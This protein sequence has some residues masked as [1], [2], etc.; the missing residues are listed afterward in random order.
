MGSCVV[1]CNWFHVTFHTTPSQA[2]VFA[3]Q[4]PSLARGRDRC[5]GGYTAMKEEERK[6]KKKWRHL[7]Q[8]YIYSVYYLLFK[9]ACQGLCQVYQGTLDIHRHLHM[10][11]I[12]R[13]IHRFHFTAATSNLCLSLIWQLIENKI[14]KWISIK[15]RI[16]QTLA[17]QTSWCF[18]LLLDKWVQW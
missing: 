18:P 12:K 1:S 14:I 17:D 10:F 7:F 5:V 16:F 2:P 11:T 6:K 9:A 3:L 8:N 13:N 4:M 15:W